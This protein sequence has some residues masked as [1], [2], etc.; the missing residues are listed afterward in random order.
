VESSSS[1]EAEGSDVEMSL[2]QRGK[3]RQREKKKQKAKRSDGWIWLENL[4]RGQKLG[5]AKLAE[6]KME[7]KCMGTFSV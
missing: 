1:S 2:K 5:D 6:Y 7:S 4:T 3:Q